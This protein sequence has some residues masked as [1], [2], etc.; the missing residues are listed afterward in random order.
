MKKPST[1]LHGNCG[2]GV[3]QANSWKSHGLMHGIGW[4]GPMGTDVDIAYYAVKKGK[5]DK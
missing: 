5:E 1:Q 4:H 2:P 3:S